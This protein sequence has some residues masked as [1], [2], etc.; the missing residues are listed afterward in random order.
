MTFREAEWY[1]VA[2]APFIL[3]FVFGSTGGIDAGPP[4]YWDVAFFAWAFG[5]QCFIAGLSWR[6]AHRTDA[7]PSAVPFFIPFVVIWCWF[8]WGIGIV[9]AV[10]RLASRGR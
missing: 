10:A 7:I 8:A 3:L 6:I 2:F 4:S 5:G 1:L 9:T